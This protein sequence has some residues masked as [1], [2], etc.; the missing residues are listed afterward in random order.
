MP[1]IT[2]KKKEYK[3]LDLKKWI[4]MQMAASGKKQSDVGKVLGISQCAVSERL[5]DKKKGGKIINPDPFSYGD[6]VA[7]CEL[8]EVSGEERQKLLTL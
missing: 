5:K 1:R 3:V 8:F 4:R 2:A 7:L 6:V